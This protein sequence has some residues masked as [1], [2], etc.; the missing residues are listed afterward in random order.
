MLYIQIIFSNNTSTFSF[1]H[2]NV[3]SRITV[4]VVNLSRTST[5]VTFLECVQNMLRE[6]GDV[7]LV[8]K[9]S[10]LY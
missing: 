2:P 5:I 4:S 9:I 1:Y 6:L 10:P 7:T 8:S 3:I